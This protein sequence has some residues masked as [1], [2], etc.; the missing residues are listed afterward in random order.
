MRFSGVPALQAA[1]GLRVGQGAFVPLLTITH[2]YIPA[3]HIAT[4]R[5]A[6]LGQANG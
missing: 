1:W 3:A 4:W 2:D 6:V 5:L